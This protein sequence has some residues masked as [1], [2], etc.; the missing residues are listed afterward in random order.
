MLLKVPEVEFAIQ[1]LHAP[2]IIF[3][4]DAFGEL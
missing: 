4:S 3:K 2:S 1:Y